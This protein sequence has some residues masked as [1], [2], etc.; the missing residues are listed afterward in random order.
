MP[1]AFNNAL[2]AIIASLMLLAPSEPPVTKRVVIKGFRPSSTRA[3]SL[4]YPAT[5]SKISGRSGI[6]VMAAGD[7]SLFGNATAMCLVSLAPMRLA[8][9]ASAFASW[10][11]SG[12]LAKKA[13][14]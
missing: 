6:P 8:I 14:R 3:C 11:T 4:S 10:I 5:A 2:E 12:F 13:A 1:A 9:P 7:R